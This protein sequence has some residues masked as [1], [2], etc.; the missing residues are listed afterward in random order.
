MTEKTISFEA[1][2]LANMLLMKHLIANLIGSGNFTQE[3]MQT[4]FEATKHE[5]HRTTLTMSPEEADEL[6]S[7]IWRDHITIDIKAKPN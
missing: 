7:L 3:Q 6:F 4:V 5:F 2:A 1:L